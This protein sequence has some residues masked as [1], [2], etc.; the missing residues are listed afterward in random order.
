MSQPSIQFRSDIKAQIKE[1][2]AD[3][4]LSKDIINTL[5]DIFVD[6]ITNNVSEL[7]IDKNILGEI[8]DRNLPM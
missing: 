6:G 2:L 3:K 8:S 7:K 5:T 1:K 4:N